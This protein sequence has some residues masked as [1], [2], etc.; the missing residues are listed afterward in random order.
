MSAAYLIAILSIWFGAGSV[1]DVRVRE[2]AEAH[3]AS[4]YPEM[5]S[6]LDVRVERQTGELAAGDVRIELPSAAVPR[7]RTKVDLLQRVDQRWER[8][9]WALLY[10]A[11]FDSVAMMRRDVGRDEPLQESDVTAAWV[12]TTRFHGEPVTAASFASMQATTGVVTDRPVS[13]GDPLRTSD[14]RAPW[15]VKTGDAVSV[16]YERPGLTLELSG[17]AREPGAVD[18]EIRVFCQDTG[19]TYRARI[20]GKG[21]SVWLETL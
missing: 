5:A 21:R 12:E 15:A 9:G 16:R 3:L 8:V 11:H 6:R 18:D 7:A 10:V 14:I 19:T 4:T 13:A 2:A 1:T 17:R 20:T